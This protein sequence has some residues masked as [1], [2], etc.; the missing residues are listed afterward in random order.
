MALARPNRTAHKVLRLMLI[1]QQLADVGVVWPQA[2][3]GC[4]DVSPARLKL[5]QMLVELCLNGGEL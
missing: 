5:C 3:V 4:I 2:A 1:L